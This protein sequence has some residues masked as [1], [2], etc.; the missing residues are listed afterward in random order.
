MLRKARVSRRLLQAILPPLVFPS[1]HRMAKLITRLSKEAVAGLTGSAAGSSSGHAFAW[2]DCLQGSYGEVIYQYEA[3]P[4]LLQPNQLRYYGGMPFNSRHPFL[5]YYQTGFKALNDFYAA[6]Q[7]VGIAQKHYISQSSLDFAPA[8]LNPAFFLPWAPPLLDANKRGENGL[9]FS[10]GCQ[11]YGPCTPKKIKLEAARLD[12]VYRSI[13]THGYDPL[14]AGGFP[15]GYFLLADHGH[16]LQSVFLVLGGQHRVAAMV[17]LGYPAIPCSFQPDYPRVIRAS[18]ASH[19]PLVR[20]GHLTEMQ[21][22]VIFESYFR[23]PDQPL[24]LQAR[25]SQIVYSSTTQ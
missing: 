11:H 17:A 14:I 19:W 6:H 20:A 4:F 2:D 16:D 9:D 1:V 12:R 21:A 22:L 15:V 5:A 23:L 7:P 3:R 25:L 24:Q 18:E 10:H 8:G 13:E